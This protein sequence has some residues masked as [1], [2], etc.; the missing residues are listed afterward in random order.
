MFFLF[1]SLTFYESYLPQCK[2]LFLLPMYL[3]SY[4]TVW[5]AV[6]FY[7]WFQNQNK[8]LYNKLVSIYNY[9]LILI[10]SSL[11]MWCL[12]SL[13]YLILLF[14]NC[15]STVYMTFW[16]SFPLIQGKKYPYLTLSVRF[17]PPVF[18]CR[19]SFYLGRNIKPSAMREGRPSGHEPRGKVSETLQKQSPNPEEKLRTP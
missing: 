8:P 6:R 18:F 4:C 10:F 5:I 9:Q 17:G 11:I 1:L 2:I 15:R 16:L 12:V 13:Y 3:W 19:I 7:F 14:F